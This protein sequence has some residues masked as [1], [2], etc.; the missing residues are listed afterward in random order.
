MDS[1]E[2][3]EKPWR[4]LLSLLSKLSK[5]GYTSDVDLQQAKSIAYESTYHGGPEAGAYCWRSGK[6]GLF[7]YFHQNPGGV[8][9]LF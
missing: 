8:K 6:C 7:R 4:G 2:N 9:E 3:G 5:I 1:G